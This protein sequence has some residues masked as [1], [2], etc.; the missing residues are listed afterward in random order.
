MFDRLDAI[1]SRVGGLANDLDESFERLARLE[2]VIVN[3]TNP[4][5]L[6]QLHALA[7]RVTALEINGA[8][9]K[10]GVITHGGGM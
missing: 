1:N 9:P 7:E 8:V 6:R 4:E 10:R 5:L 3:S 2:G